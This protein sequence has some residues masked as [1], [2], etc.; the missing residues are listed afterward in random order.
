MRSIW[1]KPIFR[2]R[3]VR[4]ADLNLL[5]AIPPTILLCR[6]VLQAAA[7]AAPAALEPTDGIPARRRAFLIFPA[8]LEQ[9]YYPDYLPEGYRRAYVSAGECVEI[10]F[11]NSESQN[12][13]TRSIIRKGLIF[14]KPPQKWKEYFGQR[15]QGDFIS[16]QSSQYRS[17]TDS[18]VLGPRRDFHTHSV[19]GGECSATANFYAWR[20]VRS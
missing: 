2:R 19:R 18:S 5:Q 11:E 14:T 8:D 13:M 1:K 7:E 15:Q 20:R 10:I 4:R 16:P 3:I 9:V 6:R 17:R 12:L